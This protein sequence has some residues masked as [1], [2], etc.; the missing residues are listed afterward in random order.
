MTT[1]FSVRVL[2]LINYVTLGNIMDRLFLS[3]QKLCVEALTPSV[4]LFEDGTCKE[5]IKFKRD[6][7][8]ESFSSRVGVYVRDAWSSH[9][10]SAGSEPDIVSTR[11]WV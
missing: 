9:C 2:Q 11:M 8:V 6:H 5:V 7:K 4:A 1:G 10:G 3:P